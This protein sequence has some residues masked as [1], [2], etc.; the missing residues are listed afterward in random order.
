V[1]PFWGDEL[2][3]DSRTLFEGNLY[4][5][6]D[7]DMGQRVVAPLDFVAE[8]LGEVMEEM[9]SRRGFEPKRL[10]IEEWHLQQGIADRLNEEFPTITLS[11][12][13]LPFGR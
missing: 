11:G 8:E 2:I 6:E 1:N 5:Y 12:S 13:L 4:T 9:K 7:Y 3:F 10:G